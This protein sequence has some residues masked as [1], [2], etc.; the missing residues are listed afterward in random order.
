[1][2]LVEASACWNAS[3]M[4]CC[5]PSAIPMPVS[6]HR[7]GD[8]LART[9]E[10][11]ARELHPRRCLIDRELDLPLRGELERVRQQV[12]EDLL[13]PLHV[14]V[15]HLRSAVPGADLEGD[16]LLRRDLP[17]R[18]VD[19][20][21]DVDDRDRVG[22]DLQLARFDLREVEDL[23]DE[24]EEIVARRVDRSRVLDLPERERLLVVLRQELR[25]DEQAVEWRP[26]LVR[27]VREELGLV[28]RH[29]RQLL[30]LLSR[31]R[32]A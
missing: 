1:M 6:R 20:V 7:E 30:R 23:A 32:E 15:H 10:D 13:E 24:R 26:Q 19:V 2:R 18:S 11:V 4:S 5:F 17:E 9:A 22:L 3:K 14:R 29:Q 21:A 28:L 31:L 25:Q 12:L 27:H 8:D 16:V